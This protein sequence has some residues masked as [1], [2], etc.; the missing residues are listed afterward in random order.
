MTVAFSLPN[1]QN[2]YTWTF[3]VP[4]GTST[5]TAPALPTDLPLLPAADAGIVPT[6][7]RPIVTF[8]EADAFDSAASFRQQQGAIMGPFAARQLLSPIPVLAANGTFRA[9]S[10]FQLR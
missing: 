9:T 6:F 5:V 7:T 4:P 3:V 8:I 10:Y 2:T 1:D